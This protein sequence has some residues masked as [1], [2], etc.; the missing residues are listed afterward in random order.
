MLQYIF[1]IS[2]RKEN[3]RM[4]ELKA[5]TEQECNSWL[6]AIDAARYFVLIKISKKMKRLSLWHAEKF[7]FNIITELIERIEILIWIALL[8]ALL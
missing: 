4:Y 2:Y 1:Q 5:E 3:S 8:Q 6:Q 7:R